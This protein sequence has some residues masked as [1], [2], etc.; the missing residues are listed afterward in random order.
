MTK[1]SNAYTGDSQDETWDH[2]IKYLEESGV[3]AFGITDYFSCDSF[4]ELKRRYKEHYSNSHKALF[5][6]IEFRLNDAIDDGNNTPHIHVIFSNTCAEDKLARFL[7]TLKTFGESESGARIACSELKTRADFGSA[8]VSLHELKK[9]LVDTFGEDEDYLIA[10][11]AKNDGVRTTDTNVARKVLISDTIDKSSHIFFGGPDSRDYFLS[12]DRYPDAKKKPVLGCSDAHSFEELERLEG[13]TPNFPSTWIKADL[14]FEGLKQIFYEPEL[15]VHLGDEPPIHKRQALKPN[16]LLSRLSIKQVE[17][18]DGRNGQWF[19]NI[20]LPFNPELTAIIGNKGSG[21]SAIADILGLLGESR[22]ED[23]FSFLSNN[24]RDKK[25]RQKGYAENFE[26]VAT[27]QSGSLTPTKKLSES[28]D[29]SKPEAVKYLPQNYFE[30]LTNALAIEEFQEKIEDVVFSHVEESDKM[31]ANHFSELQEMKTRLSKKK[32]SELKAQLRELNIQILDLE[33]RSSPEYLDE[34]QRLLESK[35]AEL[36][37]LEETKPDQMAEPESGSTEQL[38]A[39]EEVTKYTTLLRNLAAKED[40]LVAEIANE[41]ERLHKLGELNSRLSEVSA[42]LEKQE[43]DIKSMCEDLEIDPSSLLEFKVNETKAVNA[44]RVSQSK[45]IDLEGP[46]PLTIN[47]D[48]DFESLVDLRTVRAAHEFVESHV[49]S[50]K[51]N[52]SA[53]L[54]KYQSYL[55]RVASWD[56]AIQKV[57]GGDTSTVGTIKYIQE[58]VAKVETILSSDLPEAMKRRE[59]IFGEIFESKTEV[60]KFYEDLKK[61]VESELEDASTEGFSVDIDTSFS[62]STTFQKDLLSFVN[63]RRRGPFNPQSEDSIDLESDIGEVDWDNAGAIVAYFNV[64]LASMKASPFLEQVEKP[65]EFYDFLFSLDYLSPKYE[66]RLGGKGLNQLSPGE[67]G[68]LLL[69]FYLSLDKEDIPLIIDQPEDNL[70]N[71]SIFLTLA[72]CIRNAKRRRQVILITH[73]PNLAVGADAEQVVCVQLDKSDDYKFSLVA[74]SLENPEINR[75]VV[76]V[77]EGTKPAFIQRRLRYNL[78]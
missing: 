67:K 20:D 43:E 51:E 8:S 23:Y 65:K 78:D 4:F 16:R 26:A 36:K 45:I 54:R 38:Q 60:K 74:G 77:L 64:V 62:L 73:N 52:L 66:L 2:F 75:R 30:H 44:I 18:Y 40:R 19:Q 61:S 49:N 14:T 17:D 55:E 58:Q 47:M 9:A 15:R 5:P 41:K 33:E 10:F 63:R 39:K 34:Q 1:L 25:F 76:D 42:Y 70:D 21:K 71:E 28:V 11:P 35:Q 32:T 31:N 53:P 50:L 57:V 37:A 6:N 59:K 7:S 29:K 56:G 48:T 27:W 24:S 13:N 69:V 72:N 12:T 46:M 3:E 68:L 22:Q